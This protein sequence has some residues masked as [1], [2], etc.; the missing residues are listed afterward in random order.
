MEHWRRIRTTD[1]IDKQFYSFPDGQSA[2]NLAAA[3]LCHIAGT[4]RSTKR[5]L[6][7]AMLIAVLVS[8][9]T[10]SRPRADAGEATSSATAS[11]SWERR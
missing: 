11:E 8:G 2:L 4:A 10:S 7:I 9:S 5:Y 3:R 6:N 1:E